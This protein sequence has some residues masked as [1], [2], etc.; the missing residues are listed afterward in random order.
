MIKT[1]NNSQ[2]I[3]TIAL[4]II[5]IAILT[6]ALC[7]TSYQTVS[8]EQSAGAV[9]EPVAVE[10]NELYASTTIPLFT[11]ETGAIIVGTGGDTVEEI[12]SSYECKFAVTY[13]ATKQLMVIIQNIKGYDEKGNQY[14][15]SDAVMSRLKTAKENSILLALGASNYDTIYYNMSH[16]GNDTLNLTYNNYEP[17]IVDRSTLEYIKANGGT[18]ML[19]IKENVAVHNTYFHL[20]GGNF[21]DG[22]DWDI[23]YAGQVVMG[24]KIRLAG[25]P[26]RNGYKF[27]GWEYKGNVYS[28]LSY[29]KCREQEDM[30]FKAVWELEEYTIT[31]KNIATMHQSSSGVNILK[32][33]DNS[34]TY[35]IDN[36]P[37][38]LLSLDTDAYRETAGGIPFYTNGYDTI[39][40]IPEEYVTVGDNTITYDKTQAITELALGTYG[41][42]TFYRVFEPHYY[43]IFYDWNGG[44]YD[45]W[46]AGSFPS[47]F[48]P[49]IK[50]NINSAGPPSR[51]AYEFTGWKIE[52]TNT[53]IT[54]GNQFLNYTNDIT[55]IAQ[56]K[57]LK[58]TISYK[59]INLFNE[60]IYTPHKNASYTI[61]D[62]V[63]M[64][65]VLKSMTGFT[66]RDFHYW[67]PS[68][69][70]NIV[71]G[72]KVTLDE[73]YSTK[74]IKS[75]N[76]GE[77]IGDLTFYAVAYY[78]NY[79]ITY[80]LNSEPV[81]FNTGVRTSYTYPESKNEEIPLPDM[82][83][84]A[85]IKMPSSEFNYICVGWYT[86]EN[87]SGNAVQA[88]SLNS[89]SNKVYY[90]KI[91]DT[92]TVTYKVLYGKDAGYDDPDIQYIKEHNVGELFTADYI[93]TSAYKKR[94]GFYSIIIF[95]SVVNEY[96]FKGWSLEESTYKEWDKGECGPL[97]KNG[98][99]AYT[100]DT[101][102]YAVFE[103]TKQNYAYEWIW[104]TSFR[105][106]V[107]NTMKNEMTKEVAYGKHNVVF[108]YIIDYAN[109]RN[110]TEIYHSYTTEADNTT[111]VLP[112]TEDFEKSI[113]DTIFGVNYKFVGWTLWQPEVNI[114][115]LSVW[116][117]IR[118]KDDFS[119]YSMNVITTQEEADE[120]KVTG[121]MALIGVFVKV[122]VWNSWFSSS[123]NAK[124]FPDK[125]NGEEEPS[126]IISVLSSF[127]GIDMTSKGFQDF[128]KFFRGKL[129]LKE[130]IES[131]TWVKIVVIVI[132]IAIGISIIAFI[133]KIIIA[134][135]NA[136]AAKEVYKMSK[137][138]KQKEPKELKE[139]ND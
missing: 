122:S 80:L 70:I 103:K 13:V 96:I 30:V 11:V 64:D 82:S 47:S 43:E 92:A 129:S 34:Q 10:P 65:N 111:L 125:D 51:N 58:Y 123:D 81:Q 137:Q 32:L 55:L 77:Q 29:I 19:W 4:A 1:K 17:D 98:D 120:I 40:W 71:D 110:V 78:I 2:I 56:W 85:P 28:P 132:G 12:I 23:Y 124:P 136:K 33:R 57:P 66:G 90:L 74:A 135:K 6:G 88:I 69:Y 112:N 60:I 21:N 126:S 24:E 44:S 63:S 101:T 36:T 131:Y 22:T 138:I 106:D 26:I 84:I 118:Y 54:E 76:A 61:E 108:S 15:G 72:N 53:I 91:K 134:I 52:G 62:N 127:F 119:K 31:Y 42:K 38:A 100:E 102:L 89:S 45:N 37:Y 116:D 68:S 8:A 67:I 48:S 5:A 41:N 121:N 130:A 59:Y 139:N 9:G 97:V 87:L 128:L 16:S 39:G 14:D 50:V 133:A 75:W 83:T 7:T 93:Y 109:D 79:T 117:S 3:I 107:D 25:T 35:T 20:N 46:Q 114:Y 73:G 104:N 94:G 95:F 113:E 86:N 105:I 18:G 27:K 99:F 115:M 49:A